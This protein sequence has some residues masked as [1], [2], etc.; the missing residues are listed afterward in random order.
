[1]GW[2]TRMQCKVV[3]GYPPRHRTTLGRAARV[4]VWAV[5]LSACTIAARSV[6]APAAPVWMRLELVENTAEGP[7]FDRCESETTLKKGETARWRVFYGEARADS[8]SGWTAIRSSSGCAQAGTGSAA[9]TWTLRGSPYFLVD[10]AVGQASISGR[11]VL[12]EAAFSVQR[13]TGFAQDGAAVYETR[14][15]KRTVRVPDGGSAVVPILVASGKETDEFRVSELLL[16]F[17]ASASGS[18]PPVEYGEIA[19]AADVPRAEIFLD[20]GFVGRTSSDGPIVLA[21]VRVGEREVI[22]RDASGREARTVARVEK[23]RRVSV[24]LALMKGPPASADGLRPLGRNPQG[25]EEFWRDKDGAIVVRIPGGEF[26]MGSPEGEGD[27]SERPRHVVRVKGFL[28]DK[29]EV[30]W[31]QYKRFLAASSQ[32]PPKSPIWGMP[33]AFPASSVTWDEARAFCAWAGGRLPTEAEWER[34]ARG[35]D[36]RRYPWGN[37][38]D[39]WRCNT[40]DGGP[41]A[42][43]PAAAFPDCVS[44]YGVLDLAGSFM[45]WCSD[46]YAEVYDAKAPADNPT[47]P[48]TGTRRVSRGGAWMSSAF[49]VSVT[50]RLGIDPTVPDPMRGLRC[51]QKDQEANGELKSATVSLGGIPPSKRIEVRVETLANRKDGPGESCEVS[52]AMSASSAPSFASWSTLGEVGFSETESSG[53]AGL[54]LRSSAGHCGSGAF[55]GNSPAPSGAT[56]APFLIDEVSAVVGWDSGTMDPGAVGAVEISLA[57]TSRQL[58]GFSKEGKPLYS[59]LVTSRRST[60]LEPG[61]EQ[62]VPVLVDPRGLEALDVHEVLIRIRAGWAGREGATEYGTVAVTEAAPGSEIVLDGGVAGHVGADGSLVLGSVPVGQREVRVRGVSGP[63][64]SR[65]VVV[66]QGRTVLVAPGAADGG[67]L[68]QPMLTPTSKNPEGFQEYQRV[69][70]GA[71]MVQ[72]P[73]GEFLMGNLQT[74]GAPLPH[75]VYVSTFLMD[76]LPLTVG[77]FKRFAAATGRPLPPD[78]YWGVHD[79]FP[80]AF[81]RWDEAKAYCEW[82]G[83]RL[84]TEAEREKATRGT[85]GRMWPWGSVPPSPER[86]VFRRNWGQEGNDAVGIRPAGASPYGLLD[87]GGNMWEFCEDWWDADYFKSSPQKDPPGPKTGR[88]QVVKGGSWDSRPTVLS[89]SSRNFSYTGYREGDFGFRCASDPPR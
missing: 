71:V 68:P 23:G 19:I 82:A 31:G 87:T 64:V 85:D 2:S 72:I 77:L 45:E 29:T 53:K 1:M 74:E 67:S 12:M 79:N 34:A 38:F 25:G 54:N 86:G 49:A 18:R 61:E 57:L 8:G 27:P 11:E 5:V 16:K 78:P 6:S 40:Q 50:S 58:T 63:V 65:N 42:P 9:T 37:T 55:P 46:W 75:T 10:V 13:L 89:A 60:R 39:P 83:G 17:R 84:P 20:G 47:G 26:Q 81:I 76:K 21:A 52:Q 88:A 41:H 48:E 7:A 32:P 69:R 59:A 80:V 62:L 43:T 30:T 66:V 15:E 56:L 44:P 22:V 3:S 28:M 51:A 73:E 70:D 35:D 24:S 33:E 4:F 14:T 36:V